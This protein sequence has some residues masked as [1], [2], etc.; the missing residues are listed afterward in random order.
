[1]TKREGAHLIDLA[2]HISEI[3]A[4]PGDLRRI[5]DRTVTMLQ[6]VLDAECCSIM[7]LDQKNGV[8]RMAASTDIEPRLWSQIK[9]PLGEGFA[10][11]VAATGKPLLVRDASDEPDRS[12]SCKQRYSSRSFMCAPMKAK[13]RIIGVINITNRRDGRPFRPK[14]LD[15]IAVLANFVAL[16][17][18]NANLIADTDAINHRLHNVLEGIGDGVIAVDTR[19]MILHHNEI[20]THYLGLR[21][22]DCTGLTLSE[23]VPDDILPTV[24]ELF[25][26]T[27]RQRQHLHKDVQWTIDKSGAPKPLTLSTTPLGDGRGGAPQGVVFV[28]HDMT[29]HH[30]VDEL[31]RIDEAKNNFLAIVSHELRTPLT[32]IKGAVHLLRG[33]VGSRLETE[34]DQLFKIIEQNSERLLRQIINVLDVANIQTH[35]ISLNLKETD[36]RNLIDR[37]LKQ[38]G[39]QA[40]KKEIR[41]IQK[42]GDDTRAVID[43][44]KIFRVIA[45]LLDNA[46]KFTPRG[47]NVLIHAGGGEDEVFVSIKDT[48]QGIDPAIRERIF[49]KF[50]QGEG[51]LTRQSGGCGIG[52]Y[53]ARAFAELHGGRI[54]IRNLREGGC[55]FKLV[56]PRI[57]A[58]EAVDGPDGRA[59]TSFEA[60]SFP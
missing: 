25:R 21:G 8:L 46:V 52:L 58:D 48:G 1:M 57:E 36:L 10:G 50:V 19:E 45:H 53:V 31:E 17:I 35:S 51:P 2:R 43:D 37:S 42:Y 28:I 29:L 38:V 56:V 23:A 20:A 14:Q 59:A 49:H 54:E 12:E 22:L 34:D 24:R 3:V 9:A 27:I 6:S 4:S 15:T 41:I 30:K 55:E 13:G 16:A 44:D 18:E 33:R 40:A 5:F 47:G 60:T 39:D 26:Q 32:S 11:K 7:L